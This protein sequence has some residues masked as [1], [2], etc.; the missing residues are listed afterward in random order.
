VWTESIGVGD[1]G[2]CRGDGSEHEIALVRSQVPGEGPFSHERYAV[3]L[4][5][6]LVPGCSE[7]GPIRDVRDTEPREPSAA[8]TCAGSVDA[9]TRCERAAAR[10][11]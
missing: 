2:G 11:Q 3:V 6:V 10:V 5:L 4:V 8:G 1:G 9:D 7:A